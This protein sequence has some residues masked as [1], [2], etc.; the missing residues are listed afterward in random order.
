MLLLFLIQRV[1]YGEFR[2]PGL[3]HLPSRFSR[4][5]VVSAN[6]RNTTWSS[7]GGKLQSPQI[8]PQ[9]FQE[10]TRRNMSKSW[11]AE[12]SSCCRFLV[13]FDRR[14]SFV[15]THESAGA[16]SHSTQTSNSA[17][18]E[19]PA[20]WAAQLSDLSMNSVVV[21]F[22]PTSSVNTYNLTCMVQAAL[23]YPANISL[24]LYIYIYI[25]IRIYMCVYIYIYIY[26]C[27]YDT[28]L[29]SGY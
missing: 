29:G 21:I 25:H 4:G 8:S 26:I 9:N 23:R 13:L 14:P 15:C 1:T 28:L 18:T 10:D 11:L 12:L 5:L 22:E 7:Y 6:L 17:S 19:N 24:S 20:A 16:G 2:E 27:T 3:R